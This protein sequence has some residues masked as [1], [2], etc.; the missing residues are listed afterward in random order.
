MLCKVYII[1]YIFKDLF[2]PAN[3]FN[4]PNLN[5][6]YL[7]HFLF[8]EIR[9]PPKTIS[10]VRLIRI[11]LLLLSVQI[12]PLSLRWTMELLLV[13]VI[14][15]KMWLFSLLLLGIISKRWRKSQK[16]RKASTEDGNTFANRKGKCWL[17]ENY[18][19]QNDTVFSKFSTVWH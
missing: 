7:K 16:K 9:M 12:S 5:I 15:W 10:F 2:T 13:V 19:N 4:F 1:S 18:L 11:L 3:F 8:I 17:N 14:K 6:T